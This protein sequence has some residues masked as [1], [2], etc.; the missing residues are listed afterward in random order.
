MRVGEIIEI[1]KHPNAEKLYIEKV[2]LGN[3]NVIQ[4][5]SGL[6]PY[7]SKE[8]LLHKRII[9]VKNLAPTK[10]RGV[11]SQGMLLA[12]EDNGIVGVLLAKDIPI[13]SRVLSGLDAP[14]KDEISFDEFLTLSF[15]VEDGKV[16][17]N[18]GELNV[19]NESIVPDK[20]IINGSVS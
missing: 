9:V 16:F 7:Y 11:L 5:V 18:D 3:G 2:D 17:L 10:L 1:E 4:I 8:E 14:P 13:G 19:E 6:V 20:G 12:A 15:V